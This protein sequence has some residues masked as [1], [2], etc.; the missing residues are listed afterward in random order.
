MSR[1][2]ER[3]PG[4]RPRIGL[5]FGLA[6]SACSIAAA[7]ECSTLQDFGDTCLAPLR[8]TMSVL[9]IEEECEILVWGVASKVN[10]RM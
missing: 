5:L 2:I 4:M 10:I 6:L 8:R 1:T 3:R 7:N 9:E